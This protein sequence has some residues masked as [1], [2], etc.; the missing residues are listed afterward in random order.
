M[1]IDIVAA[2][3]LLQRLRA[4]TVPDVTHLKLLLTHELV[5][6]IKVAPRRHSIVLRARAAAGD[7]LVDAR[8]ALQIQ[9]IMIESDRPSLFFP[10][11]H[12]VRQLFVLFVQQRQVC[13]SQRQRVGRIRDHRLHGQLVKTQLGHVFDVLGEVGIAVGVG[14]AHVIFGAVRGRRLRAAGGRSL[15]PA[16]SCIF[17]AAGPATR[18]HQP[19]ELRH[20]QIVAPLIIDRPSEP[21]VDFLSSVQAQDHVVHFPVGEFDD[22]IV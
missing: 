22:L 7:P 14:A 9:H 19:L 18:R 20:D 3:L 17:R 5:T 2:E 8:A 10:L 6:G 4:D 12:P 13:L 15:V 1:S 16:G 11:Q 21:V